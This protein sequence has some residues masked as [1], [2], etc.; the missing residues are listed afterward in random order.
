MHIDKH[1]QIYKV[2]HE[3]A[4]TEKLDGTVCPSSCVS[5]C[6][7]VETNQIGPKHRVAAI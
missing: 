2:N 3:S 6:M 4:S 1:L 7:L 5:V